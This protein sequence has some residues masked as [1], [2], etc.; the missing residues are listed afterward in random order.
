MYPAP[1]RDDPPTVPAPAARADGAPP[2]PPSVAPRRSARQR[3]LDV[4]AGVVVGSAL[5][6]SVLLLRS[7]WPPFDSALATVARWAAPA[8]GCPGAAVPAGH[9][10]HDSP[11]EHHDPHVAEITCQDGS[12]LV[13]SVN[14]R[15]RFSATLAGRTTGT[16]CR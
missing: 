14:E 15:R 12:R 13:L 8:G 1:T 16:C 7:W 4:T 6:S 3:L 9:G 11:T 2:A 5:T 10:S